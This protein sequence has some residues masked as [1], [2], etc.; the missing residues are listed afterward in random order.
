MANLQMVDP[1]MTSAPF[2][3]DPRAFGCSLGKGLNGNRNCHY[4]C[5]GKCGNGWNPIKNGD[6]FGGWFTKFTI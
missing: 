5:A 3:A 2:A 6:D 1:S 4:H